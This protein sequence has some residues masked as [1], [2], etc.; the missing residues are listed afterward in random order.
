[1]EKNFIILCT[2]VYNAFAYYQNILYGFFSFILASTFFPSHNL[3]FS[4]FASF[5]T[6]AVGFL[7]N[8][9]GGLLFGYLGDRYGR[10]YT[11]NLSIILTS[12]PTFLIGVLPTYEEIGIVTS[13]ALIFCRFLQGLSV[14]GQS[15]SSI[16]FIVEHSFRKKVNFACGLLA[17]SSLMGAILGTFIGF[18]CLLDIMP[19]WAW[20]IPF[21]LG[22]LLG[23]ISYFIMRNV[24]ETEEYMNAQ[25][26]DVL[27]QR[28]IINVIKNY[29]TNFFCTMGVSIA[30]FIPF[31]I[32]VIYMINYVFSVN[33]GFSPAQIMITTTFF[34]AIWG[35]FLPLM[36]YL[37][38][39]IGE[40]RVMQASTLIMLF[41][42]FPLCWVIQVS[43]SLPLTFIALVLLCVISAAYVAP[44]GTLMTKLFPVPLRCSGISVASGIGNA[45]FGGTA[46]LIGFLLVENTGM[47]S[48]L[49]LYIMFGSLI[50]YIAIKKT[51]FNVE[52]S[53]KESQAEGS[54]ICPSDMRS[55]D[56]IPGVLIAK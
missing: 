34:M 9:F 41:V 30:T 49:A 36:G 52:E 8:P 1:M 18:L 15:N 44:S 32:I 21:L 43:L 6:F 16:V 48:S 4:I 38:D 3:T 11:I 40:I 39:K 20:R 22:G 37:A 35:I 5:S 27:K 25:R 13:L 24:N 12:F 33:F 19:A 46:P 42:S 47:L 10:K 51:N 7:A 23:S 29:P 28:P 55:D 45:L 14:G 53:Q 50:G 54:P 31:Y 2:L 26:S 56:E 17:S